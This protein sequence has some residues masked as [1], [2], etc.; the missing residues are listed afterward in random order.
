MEGE[1]YFKIQ[2]ADDKLVLEGK[3]PKIMALK[4]IMAALRTRKMKHIKIIVE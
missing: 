3:L 2:D 1:V 4:Q